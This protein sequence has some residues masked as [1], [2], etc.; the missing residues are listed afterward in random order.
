MKNA[1]KLERFIPTG[2]MKN[3]Y[4]IEANRVLIHRRKIKYIWG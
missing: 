4:K 1:M 3:G 2:D